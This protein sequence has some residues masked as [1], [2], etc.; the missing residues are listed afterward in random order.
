MLHLIERIRNQMTS[1]YPLRFALYRTFA[2]IFYKLFPSSY[3]KAILLGKVHYPHYAYCLFESAMLARKLGH[4]KIS[5]IEFGVAGGN[6]LVSIE[7]HV[8]KISKELGIGF[9]VY[10][11]DMETGLPVSDDYRDLLYK[12]NEGFFKMDRPKLEANLKSSKLV[13]GNIS[14][15]CGSFFEKYNPAPIGCIIFDVDYYTSTKDALKI[16]EAAHD[17]YLPRVHCF[18][19]DIEGTN[20]YVGELCAIKEFNNGNQYKKI[21]HPYSI[22]QTSPFIL[23]SRIFIFH[24][25]KHPDYN[26]QIVGKREKETELSIRN[27]L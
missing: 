23:A 12:F 18:F 11:F 21:A 2:S 3:L 17:R 26:K 4:S 9:E 19:D 7:R 22:E 14:D 25:F 24:D 10:G 13:I 15:T 20:E 6:G 16:F 8:E 27:I 1:P 5:V